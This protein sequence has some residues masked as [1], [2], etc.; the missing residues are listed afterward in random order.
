MLALVVC[1]E[2]VETLEA[3]LVI[4]LKKSEGD[5][6]REGEGLWMHKFLCT[7]RAPSSSIF[8]FCQWRFGRY[9]YTVK[10]AGVAAG[11]K[12]SIWARVGFENTSYGEKCRVL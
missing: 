8:L 3:P 9:N 7:N 6:E 2:G 12:T 11:P 1:E 4:A 5:E 10:R